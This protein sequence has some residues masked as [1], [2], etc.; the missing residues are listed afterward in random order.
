MTPSWLECLRCAG[1]FAI[2]AVFRG[3]PTCLASG[4]MSPVEVRYERLPDVLAPAATSGIWKWEAWLPPVCG[5]NRVSLGEG[6]TP[7]LPLQVQGVTARLFIKNETVNPTWSWKD[8][9]NAVS[10]SMARE[11]GFSKVVAI[12]TGNHGS[13][14]AAYAARAG[15]ECR[16]LCHEDAP[17]LQVALMQCYGAAVLRGGD[18]E[19]LARRL[20]DRGNIFPDTILCPRAG[21]A[22]PYGVEGFKTIAFEIVQELGRAPDRVFVPVGSGDGIYG[23]WKGFRELRESGVI[24]R[25][26]RMIACQ[27]AG[28]DSLVRAIHAGRSRVETLDHVDTAALSI[29]ER[30]TGDHA[31]RAV[32]ESNGDAVAIVDQDL[33]AAVASVGRQGLS[34][35]TSSAASVAGMK[36][37]EPASPDGETWIAIASGAGI[38]WPE[39]LLA[40]SMDN[41]SN[42]AVQAWSELR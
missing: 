28:A 23:I 14:A 20:I 7:M 37:C 34:I 38:K 26:P 32:T 8:R 18:R 29:G 6:S 42:Q 27:S 2:G 25:V 35:E 40:G 15:L 30:V 5:K 9:P 1:R 39:Q 17:D 16:V 33:F 3:C 22:N 41:K 36:M 12:S 31:A 21:F 10:I 11:F 4:Q 13:A 19:A 24:E